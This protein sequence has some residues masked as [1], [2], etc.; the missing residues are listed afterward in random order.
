MQ[1][2]ISNTYIVITLILLT[3]AYVYLPQEQKAFHLND[4][5]LKNHSNAAFSENHFST[6][7]DMK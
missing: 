5:L 2:T 4:Y 3:N 1:L 7:N 6:P